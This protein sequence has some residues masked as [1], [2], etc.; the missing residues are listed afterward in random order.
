MENILNT[1]GHDTSVWVL[2]SFIIFFAILVKAAKGFFTNT[3]DVEI[4]N[5]KNELQT[6]ENLHVEAQELLAQYQRKHMNAVK[7]AD[8]I[9]ANAEVY[10]AKIRKQAKADLKE[11]LTR[12]EEQLTERVTRMKENAIVEIQRYAAEIAVDATRDIIVAE[13]D[14]KADKAFTDNALTE[15]KTSNIH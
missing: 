3:L 12:R 11:N 8:E 10:A 5:I 2:F 14:K 1:L 4:E 13:F 15:L 6:A 7:E 9:I